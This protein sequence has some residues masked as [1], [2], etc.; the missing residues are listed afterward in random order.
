MNSN[1]I[2]QLGLP[3]NLPLVQMELVGADGNA[4]S[5]LGRFKREARKQGWDTD[6]I[7]KVTDHAMAGDY[8][9][10]LV[11]ISSFVEDIGEE[12]DEDEYYEDE[13]DDGYIYDVI[14]DSYSV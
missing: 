8:N 2:Q 7:A 10:L 3:Q 13:D 9:N 6:S 4:F 5:I 11:T 14:G 12:E 1:L